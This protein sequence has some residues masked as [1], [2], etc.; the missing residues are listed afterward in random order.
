MP[1]PGRIENPIANEQGKGTTGEWN[2]HRKLSSAG[3]T[4]RSYGDD[5]EAMAD[6]K[7]KAVSDS[8]WG[9]E[10]DIFI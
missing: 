1:T 7:I 8:F 3:S 6:M 5:F 2:N 10:N 9:T 4:K